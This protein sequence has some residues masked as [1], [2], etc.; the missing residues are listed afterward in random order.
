MKNTK[1][2]DILAIDFLFLDRSLFEISFES[3]NENMAKELE[4][5]KLLGVGGKIYSASSSPAAVTIRL[6]ETVDL[7]TETLLC[8]LHNIRAIF[9][10]CIRLYNIEGS[11]I[12]QWNYSKCSIHS[13]SAKIDAS[14][15]KPLTWK[16]ILVFES[17][18]KTI[19]ETDS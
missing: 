2:S 12:A 8:K 13:Y 15:K 5:F 1:V 16:T 6:L 17:F 11:V 4:K 3:T 19:V 18:S 9:N 10:C 14:K 7:A